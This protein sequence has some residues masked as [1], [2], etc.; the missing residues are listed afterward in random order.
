[1]PPDPE[2]RKR[3]FRAA[4]AM[5]GLTAAEFAESVEVTPTHLS[6][7]LSGKRNS[8]RVAEAID[9]FIKRHKVAA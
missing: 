6:F 7:V 3:R 9:Q 2:L 4:L 5:A 8:A 1:M